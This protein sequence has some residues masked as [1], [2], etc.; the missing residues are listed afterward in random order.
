MAET[1]REVDRYE[2]ATDALERIARAFDANPTAQHSGAAVASILRYLAHEAPADAPAATKRCPACDSGWRR[3]G[4]VPT[5]CDK[6]GGTGIAAA[7][8]ASQPSEP[9]APALLTEININD[10]VWVRVTPVGEHIYRQHWLA[11]RMDPLPLRR[12]ADGWT[13]FQ[14][15]EL[16]N[17]FGAAMYNGGRVPVETTIRV[18]TTVPAQR[19]E[20][21]PDSREGLQLT[22]W[23][24]SGN[25][26]WRWRAWVQGEWVA[27]G[28][29]KDGPAAAMKAACEW[30]ALN[31]ERFPF[32]Y[33]R[34]SPGGAG[35]GT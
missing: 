1:P 29:D 25:N 9:V 21:R 4:A 27:E 6:C 33:A 20:A 10:S 14:L 19:A 31:V 28:G 24:G 23:N 34:T 3:D 5:R 18:A 35:E 15:W 17:V 26:N 2:T 22:V 16:A 30:A 8:A 11:L 7:P 12:D 32:D 13:K